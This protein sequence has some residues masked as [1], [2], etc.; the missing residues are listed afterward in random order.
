MKIWKKIIMSCI[1]TGINKVLYVYAN[2]MS[3][4]LF[5]V[6]IAQV[7]KKQPTELIM[8]HHV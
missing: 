3:K 4:S 5:G 6:H 1:A 8:N 7:P 2:D